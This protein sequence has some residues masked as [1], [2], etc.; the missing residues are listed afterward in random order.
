MR[1]QEQADKNLMIS[2]V[3]VLTGESL[4]LHHSPCSLYLVLIGQGF[5][6]E[7]LVSQ[8]ILVPTPSPSAYSIAVLDC[9][10]EED[11]HLSDSPPHPALW[12][13]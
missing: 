8:K 5:A 7:N 11:R 12:K 6:Q 13:S 9:E 1:T 3:K 10:A 2:N 4:N